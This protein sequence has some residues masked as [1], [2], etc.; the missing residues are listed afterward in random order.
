MISVE[1]NER[2]E[3]IINVDSIEFSNSM[4]LSNL[5]NDEIK[6]YK[7]NISIN[8]KNVLFIDSTGIAMLARLMQR[9]AGPGKNVVLTEVSRDL[10]A[11]FKAMSLDGFFKL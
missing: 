4:P 7:K 3:I 10:K 6:K 1:V 2:L 8:L 5:I 11:I 9:N